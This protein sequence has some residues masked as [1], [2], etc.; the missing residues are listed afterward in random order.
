[1]SKAVPGRPTR[2]CTALP[3]PHL[4]AYS[5][6]LRPSVSG[7]ATCERPISTSAAPR[8]RGASSG[9]KWAS[10]AAHA[11]TGFKT[12]TMPS[13]ATP[14]YYARATADDWRRT[15]PTRWLAQSGRN[16]DG[17]CGRGGVAAIVKPLGVPLEMIM[18]WPRWVSKV[19]TL[20]HCTPPLDFHCSTKMRLP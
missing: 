8:L 5:E 10:T 19:V 20:Q 15:W 17:M 12:T 18:A 4:H 7:G 14:S 13:T 2:R 3:S 9:G 11:H 16:P 1:M 6:S